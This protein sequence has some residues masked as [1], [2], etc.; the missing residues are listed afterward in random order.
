VLRRA[1]SLV[2]IAACLHGGDAP[3]SFAEMARMEHD[4]I[5]ACR[6]LHVQYQV[7]EEVP[8]MRLDIHSPAPLVGQATTET[9]IDA[10]GQQYRYETH[11]DH[12]HHQR[13]LKRLAEAGV[14]AIDE[15]KMPD[16]FSDSLL[17]RRSDYSEWLPL[18]TA[19]MIMSWRLPGVLPG[20]PH[21]Q[22][23]TEGEVQPLYRWCVLH[24]LSGE[25]WYPTGETDSP[26]APAPSLNG[27]V[28]AEERCQAAGEHATLSAIV[29]YPQWLPDYRMKLTLTLV[30]LGDP[31]RWFTERIS[32]T[33]PDDE[34][35]G[36]T[37]IIT[38]RIL[39]GPS[40]VAVPERILSSENRTGRIYSECRAT[41]IEAATTFPKETW[42]ID[43]SLARSIYDSTLEIMLMPEAF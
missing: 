33:K 15:W 3:A 1:S 43:Q 29:S 10:D 5:S 27:V 6:G 9:W 14:A 18:D 19:K 12:E 38:W 41:R 24:Q 32:A 7:T 11:V 30:R 16:I 4:W 22:L 21:S 35:G 17:V 42:G 28:F 23:S 36:A 31:A 20:D 39:P 8:D 37:T 40:C 25:G 26:F 13:E 2:L 34:H